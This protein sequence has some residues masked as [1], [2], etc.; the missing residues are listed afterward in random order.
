MFNQIMHLKF[1]N[2]NILINN[3]LSNTHKCKCKF[4]ILCYKIQCN[5]ISNNINKICINLIS[6]CSNKD[7]HNFN[8]NNNINSSNNNEYEINFYVLFKL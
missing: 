8:N 6:L 4:K 1:N 5:I 7:T 2:H 3:N